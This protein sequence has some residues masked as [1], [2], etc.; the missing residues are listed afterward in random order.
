MFGRKRKETARRRDPL[1][2]IDYLHQKIA[3]YYLY[4]QARTGGDYVILSSPSR[5]QEALL[6]DSGEA[7]SC[8]VNVLSLHDATAEI[9]VAACC[10]LEIRVARGRVR[11]V[12]LEAVEVLIALA[13]HFTAIRLL[14][15][16][17][18]G[19]GVRC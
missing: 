1:D 4:G 5:L 17:A 7:S 9:Q 16:H 14:F 6:A 2:R 12:I 19:A 18:Q 15:L 8:N 11:F 10:K 3:G 13:A